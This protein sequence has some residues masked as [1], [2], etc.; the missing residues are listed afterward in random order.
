MKQYDVH[1]SAVP[2]ELFQTVALWDLC[3]EGDNVVGQHSSNQQARWKA[4]YGGCLGSHN[5]PDS[6][7]LALCN[8]NITVAAVAA[9]CSVLDNMGA[10]MIVWRIRGNIIRTEL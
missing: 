8:I 2:A 5:S 4:T 6:Q 7:V 3:S 10:M 9:H 1:C